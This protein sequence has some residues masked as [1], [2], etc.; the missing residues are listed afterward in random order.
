MTEK[1]ALTKW[2]P[3]VRTDT[4]GPEYS[5]CNRFDGSIKSEALLCVGSA[6]MAWRWKNGAFPSPGDP[7]AISERYE[8]HC[9]LAGQP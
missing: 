8:G 4:Q 1:E 6:C 2:C 9:G 3:F 5:A 7:P